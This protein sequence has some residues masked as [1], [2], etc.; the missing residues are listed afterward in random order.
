[1]ESFHLTEIARSLEETIPLIKTENRLS[2]NLKRPGL[3]TVL[4]EALVSQ[5]GETD[6]GGYALDSGSLG[7]GEALCQ[8]DGV[9]LPAPGW[10]RWEAGRWVLALPGER[11]KERRK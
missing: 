6:R 1:M 4:Q 3:R 10:Q 8:E 2:R 9:S 11:G 5:G 7:S